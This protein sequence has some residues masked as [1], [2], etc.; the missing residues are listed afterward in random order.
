M[1]R[2]SIYIDE[3]Q[4]DFEV[5]IGQSKEENDALVRSGHPQDVWFHLANMSSCHIVLKCGQHTNIIPK[6]YLNKVACMFREYKNN[7]PSRYSVIYTEIK[8]VRPS[9]ELGQVTTV[10]TRTIRV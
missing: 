6:R 9:G 4:V 10:Q 8:N 7:L 1:R 5:L 3:L 2:Q